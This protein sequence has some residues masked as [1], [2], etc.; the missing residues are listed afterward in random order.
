[1]M[2]TS[3]LF[4][5]FCGSQPSDEQS[6]HRPSPS[7]NQTIYARPGILV[8][9]IFRPSPETC[10]FGP[11]HLRFRP[12]KSPGLQALSGNYLL[13]A[14]SRSSRKVRRSLIV[15]GA[16]MPLSSSC[17]RAALHKEAPPSAAWKLTNYGFQTVE[18][19]RGIGSRGGT[20]G[21][22][23]IYCFRHTFPTRL[24]HNEW[25]S[26][27]PKPSTEP[28]SLNSM[29]ES[30]LKRR[31]VTRDRPQTN[32]FATRGLGPQSCRPG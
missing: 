24:F 2:R 7:Q 8:G 19:F 4:L 21:L 10:P 30:K 6:G 27:T 20:S 9:T 23:E 29:L 1:M 22:A 5:R 28:E 25:V 15:Y 12:S 13:T 16:S 26:A 32:V 17:W 18:H 31:L 11:N 3:T 14:R